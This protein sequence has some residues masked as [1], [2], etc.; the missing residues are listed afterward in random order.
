MKSLKKYFKNLQAQSLLEY[1]LLLAVSI[2][3]IVGL[4]MILRANLGLNKFWDD[5]RAWITK[6]ER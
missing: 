4:G 2:V 6:G 1:T 5:A 3:A